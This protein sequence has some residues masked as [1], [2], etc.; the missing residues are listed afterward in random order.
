MC[1]DAHV[2]N[3]G[4]WA[5][6]ERQLLFDVRDFDETLPR[7]FEW[8]LKRLTT[9]LHVLAD[10]E[11]LTRGCGE[12]AVVAAVEGYRTAMVGYSRMGELDLPSDVPLRGLTSEFAE[13][14]LRAVEKQSRKRT[15]HGAARRLVS[16][17]DGP[18]TMRGRHTRRR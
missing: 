10:A 16:D 18:P 17:E 2:L 5:S 3:F 9:S 6:P 4:L 1:G 8:D 15:R 7:P 14:T 11:R 13:A 12:D